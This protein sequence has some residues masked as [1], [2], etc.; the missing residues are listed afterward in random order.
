MN[1][2]LIDYLP[3]LITHFECVI[4]P[5]FGGFI[6]EKTGASINSIGNLQ[7]PKKNI[8]FNQLLNHNDGLLAN[9]I[10]QKENISYNEA[11]DL[12]KSEVEEMLDQLEKNQV[13]KINKIGEFRLLNEHIIFKADDDEN[14]L[15]DSFGLSSLGKEKKEEKSEIENTKNVEAEVV[16]KKIENTKDVEEKIVETKSADSNQKNI[17]FLIIAVVLLLSGL[18]FYTMKDNIFKLNE[19]SS[20]VDTLLNQ[21]DTLKLLEDSLNQISEQIDTATNVDPI[22]STAN[23]ENITQENS[24]NVTEIIDTSSTN[25]GTNVYCIASASFGNEKD[26]IAEK[27]QLEMIGFEA[28]IIAMKNAIRYQVIIGKYQKYQDAVN[29][30]K[31]AKNIDKKFYLLTVKENK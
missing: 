30:L 18:A 7:A 14:Y 19:K 5:E 4:I 13:L 29:E 11:L 1:Q 16:E 6:S 25:T 26:A 27:R 9:Y 10:A 2:K 31:F 12:I 22:N 17:Q 21:N 20:T 23:T 8:L 28:E 24:G 15:I 3:D